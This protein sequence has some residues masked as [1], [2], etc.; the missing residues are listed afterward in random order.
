MTLAEPPPE[1]G[2]LLAERVEERPVE[3]YAGNSGHGGAIA[4]QV[5][6]G[7]DAYSDSFTPFGFVRWSGGP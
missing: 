4:V 7:G 6:E 5:E 1:V 3:C 2:N